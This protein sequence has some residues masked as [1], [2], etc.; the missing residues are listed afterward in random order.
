MTG[1]ATRGWHSY[2]EIMAASRFRR[3]A[4]PGEALVRALASRDREGLRRLMADEVS[5]K[6]LSPGRFWEASTPDEVASIYFDEWFEETHML[7]R[8]TSFEEG[9]ALPDL[10]RVAFRFELITPSGPRVV[11][12][13][14]Y[15]QAAEGRITYLR[16]LCSGFR[17]R[18]DEVP[19]G[20]GSAR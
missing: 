7:E 11:E 9:E 13:Q 18:P 2:G 3:P 5:F 20:L 10:D 8:V 1:V 6:A 4:S 16:V 15:Y 19:A 14:T 12:Q 17:E